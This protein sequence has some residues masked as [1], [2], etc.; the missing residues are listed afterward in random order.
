MDCVSLDNTLAWNFFL[1]A[2]SRSRSGVGSLEIL[3]SYSF[4]SLS[5]HSARLSLYSP[6]VS[7]SSLGREFLSPFFPPG[8]CR[9]LRPREFGSRWNGEFLTGDCLRLQYSPSGLKLGVRPFSGRFTFIFFLIFFPST[10]FRSVSGLGF[11]S[12][13]RPSSDFLSV[14]TSS[15]NSSR[16]LENSSTSAVAS[17]FKISSRLGS[18]SSYIKNILFCIKK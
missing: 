2:S 3:S 11:F 4:L 9:L 12:G 5:S 7:F 8:D 6:F 16:N 10:I 17:S 15:S 18:V 1:R 14:R 13:V